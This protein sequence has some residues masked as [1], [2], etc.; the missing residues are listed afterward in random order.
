MG[1]RVEYY[2]DVYGARRP[3]VLDD[4][5]TFVPPADLVEAAKGARTVADVRACCPPNYY[6]AAELA[7]IATWAGLD[8]TI[9]DAA[10]YA[11]PSKLSKPER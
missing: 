8:P 11:A 1:I 2:R 7:K 9:C 3:R 10:S 5:S 6:T 4:P